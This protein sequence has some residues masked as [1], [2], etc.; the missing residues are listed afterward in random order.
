MDSLVQF[1]FEQ[2]LSSSTHRTYTTGINR[3][4]K[5]C[6]V[7]DI[8]DPF[9]LSQTLLCYFVSYLANQDLSTGTIKVYLSALR[10][11]QVSLGHPDP[12]HSSMPKLKLVTNGVTRA[13]AKQP[14]S[15]TGPSRLPIT[16]TILHQIKQVWSKDNANP[17]IIML[18]AACTTAF[19]GFFRM[20]ELTV[21][22]PAAFDPSTHITI[23]DIAID[24]RDNPSLI[25]IHLKV[26]KTDQERKGVSI[27]IGKTGDDICPVAALTAY[28]AT[29][30]RGDGPLFQFKDRTP[31]TK[32]RF[33]HHV[34]AALS[35]AGYNPSLYAGHS[36]RIGAATTAAERGIEDST[37]KALGRWK[38]D[39]FQTY[40][41]IPRDKLA[42]IAPILSRPTSQPQ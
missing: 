5:F 22:S 10:H 15:S 11:K 37:I 12:Q 20:G 38:S 42:A 31:L 34:R 1:Y 13:K 17:D 7:H 4:N 2:G 30:D 3:F 40:I 33:I 26:S 8:K 21:P 36:F 23:R 18:W 32:D 27:F 25:Q 29:Q 19:F 6:L 39:T 35:S 28:L 24:K 14:S 16:P 41:R 9:P